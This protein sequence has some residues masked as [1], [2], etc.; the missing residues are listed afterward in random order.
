MCYIF[1]L[2]TLSEK[3]RLV[4]IFTSMRFLQ[5]YRF[6]RQS[7]D[8]RSYCLNAS[9]TT[10]VKLCDSSQILQ[11][12]L[13]ASLVCILP[14]SRMIGFQRLSLDPWQKQPETAWEHLEAV[15]K[16]SWA[17]EQSKRFNT[18]ILVQKSF[19]KICLQPFRLQICL[20]SVSA[21]NLTWVVFYARL[22]C[23]I[24]G[25]HAAGGQAWCQCIA[26]GSTSFHLQSYC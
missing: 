21:N 2:I 6:M 11:L 22:S 15:A 16:K 18:Q 26:N 5:A 20:P 7:Y 9:N 8:H 4:N 17:T 10:C 14:K 19:G 23:D 12:N 3:L 24:A 13:F 1:D 25:F